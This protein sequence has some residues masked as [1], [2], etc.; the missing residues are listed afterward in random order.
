[1]SST[2]WRAS[3]DRRLLG[4][5]MFGIAAALWLIVVTGAALIA[6]YQGAEYKCIVDGPHDPRAY[7][8]EAGPVSAGFIMWP[9]GRECV[10]PTANGGTV[11]AQTDDWVPTIAMVCFSAIGLWGA[12]IA[13]VPARSPK[14]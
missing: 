1:M 13:V 10:W 14:G 11:V 6:E 2:L 12:A 7:P 9:M 8:L 3:D 4:V 5:V